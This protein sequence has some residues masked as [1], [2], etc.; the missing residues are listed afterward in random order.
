MLCL[1]EYNKQLSN[2]NIPVVLQPYNV[3]KMKLLF[4]YMYLHVYKM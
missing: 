4:S 3:L 2:M 1:E